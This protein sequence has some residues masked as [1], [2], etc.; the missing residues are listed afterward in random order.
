MAQRKRPSSKSLL[1]L[2]RRQAGRRTVLGIALPILSA[3]ILALHTGQPFAGISA[4]QIELGFRELCGKFLHSQFHTTY[5]DRRLGP[6]SF[7]VLE[8]NLYRFRPALLEG[9]FGR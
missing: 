2:F 8:G 5:I 3:Q 6:R 4:K 9:V 7:L 1:D